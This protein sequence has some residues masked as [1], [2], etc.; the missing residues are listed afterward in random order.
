[1][2]FLQ[3]AAVCV[4]AGQGASA[5]VT[6][7]LSNPAG[8]KAAAKQVAKDLMSYYTGNNPGDVAGN[9]PA[10]YYWWEAGAMFGTM[11]NYWYYTG[12]TTYNEITTAAILHQTGL[13]WD[14][15]PTNQTKTLGN[16]DQGFWGLTA[17]T[18]AEVN[19]P[20]LKKPAPGWL[21][22]AQG[23]F[24][25]QAE[26][27]DL[28]NCG[29]GLRWQIFPFNNGYS[30]K[31]TISNG[32]FFNIGARLALYTGNT[33]YA[34]W[35]EKTW[36]WVQNEGLIDEK[37]NVFD[38]TNIGDNC[39]AK[40]HNQWT[41]NAGIYLLGAATMYNQT[42][43]TAQ[44]KWEERVNGLL[45]QT[46]NTFFVD[47]VMK[48]LCEGGQ[49]NVDQRSFKAYLSRWLAATTRLAPFTAATIT[50]LIAKSSAA[51]LKTCTAGGGNTQCGL[52]WTT[53]SNDGSFGVG[54]QMAVLEITQS[55]LV[56]Q[57]PDWVSAVKG[58]GN[59][60]GNVDA[61]SNSA[62]A[63]SIINKPITTKD[64]VGAAFFTALVLIGV[65]G[66]SATMMI[67]E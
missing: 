56:A 31:N 48:E 46:V 30:Y 22:L 42:N 29:G 2:R 23:V 33:T 53:G 51:A 19:F 40:D 12:D 18:A 26:R 24:N 60:T 11:V 63:D 27:W 61:G 1:M 45:N 35:A 64:R 43:G 5:A 17:M 66:G 21:A 28:Q 59:S 41:Y 34:S 54:E 13:E 36:D 57:T 6:A 32:C 67:S 25:T 38:G 37:W 49:C 3:S 15:M 47:G 44:A 14:F 16:D 58:T 55:N 7:D 4:L 8:I 65:V 9:L 52:K 39:T 50:P 62:T 20:E 10:P